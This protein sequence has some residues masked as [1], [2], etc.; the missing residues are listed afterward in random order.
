MSMTEAP[1]YL[2]GVNVEALL[3]AR[4]AFKGD[5][6]LTQ[7]QWRARNEWVNGVHSRTVIDDFTGVGGPQSHKAPVA[8][9]ADHPELFAAEDSGSTPVE[10]VLHAIAACLT[11]GIAAVATNRGITLNSVTSTIEGDMDL[12]G[13][14]GMD[15]DVRN[16]YSQIRVSFEI[17]A[18]ADADAVEKLVEQSRKRSAVYD[19]LTGNVPVEI[20]VTAN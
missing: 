6:S 8:H 11:G 10:F 4:E 17:D 12:Q 20:T 14:L 2:N 19:I 1:A 7:F 18:D 5:L 3:G 16:G 13:I 9:D 15:P